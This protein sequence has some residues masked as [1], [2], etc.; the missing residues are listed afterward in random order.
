ME[1]LCVDVEDVRGDP[2][3]GSGRV[4]VCVQEVPHVAEETEVLVIHGVYQKLDPVAV[5]T[6]LT[7]VLHHGA[8]A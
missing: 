1:V 7:V 6:E 3:A 8:D 2:P 4:F 5:L